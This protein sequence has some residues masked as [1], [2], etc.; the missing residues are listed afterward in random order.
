ML[1]GNAA[2]SQF[3]SRHSGDGAG[4]WGGAAAFFLGAAGAVLLAVQAR[5]NPEAA[6]AV[7]AGHVPVGAALLAAGAARALLLFTGAKP[8]RIAL[9]VLLFIAAAMTGTYKENP[10]SFS[11]HFSTVTGDGVTE[12]A[13]AG[14]TNE[15]TAHKKGPRG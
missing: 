6:P 10:D 11:L 1:A 8:A 14:R 4:F 2:L 13:A 12:K 15:E 7:M 3:L 5:V 9:P